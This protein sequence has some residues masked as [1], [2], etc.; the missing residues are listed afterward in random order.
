MKVWFSLVILGIFMSLIP[1]ESDGQI[2]INTNTALLG[3]GGA[4]LAA[5][6]F[7]TGYFLG[8]QQSQN[9][10][11]SPHGFF[12]RRYYGRRGRRDIAVDQANDEN[13]N[14]EFLDMLEEVLKTDRQSCTLLLTC[15]AASLDPD[16]LNPKVASLL[17]PF[18]S[19]GLSDQS[20]AYAHFK[21]AVSAGKRELSCP[22][23]YDTCPAP[24]D[25]LLD[26]Y[27]WTV[28]QLLSDTPA[29]V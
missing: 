10:P 13:P 16:S 2:T 1:E 25:S 17:L 24:P 4:I 28:D 18:E 12:R 20:A 6:A 29:E 5:G 22:K 23:L 14:S 7:K 26:Q 11:Y 15:H 3:L 27:L 21:E 19:E 9:R 8:S